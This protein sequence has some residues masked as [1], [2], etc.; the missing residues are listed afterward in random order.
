MAITYDLLRYFQLSQMIVA[1]SVGM[2]CEFL[3]AG[4]FDVLLRFGNAL[5]ALLI[6]HE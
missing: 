3:I 5:L 6:A 2:T 4:V 1:S